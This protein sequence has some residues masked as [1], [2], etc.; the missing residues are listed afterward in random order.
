[1]VVWIFFQAFALFLLLDFVTGVL[2]WIEDSYGK[3]RWPIVGPLVIA[4]NV[5]HHS[6]PRLFTKSPFWRRNGVCFLAGCLIF[7]VGFAITRSPTWHLYFFCFIGAF[8]NEIH[9]WSHR[10]KGENGGLITFL[11]WL[12]IIQSH[13]QHGIHHQDP[14]NRSYCLITPLLNPL[15][16]R[17]EFWRRIEVSLALVTGIVPR[18]NPL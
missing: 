8:S 4:P 16:D 5:V 13:A 11:Q 6:Q 18:A 10:T 9:C 17:V 2:H 1:M 7:G 12:W 3:E 14:K 15:L